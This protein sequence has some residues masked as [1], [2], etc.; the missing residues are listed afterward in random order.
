MGWNDHLLDDSITKIETC[1]FCGRYFECTYS[2]QVPGF[3]CMDS[4]VCP[5]CG[6][7]VETSMEYDFYTC[8]RR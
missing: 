5:Y 7:V 3:R 8:K 6:K 4:K 1:P 2:E